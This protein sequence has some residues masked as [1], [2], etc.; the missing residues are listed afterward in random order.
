MENGDLLLRVSEAEEPTKKTILHTGTPFSHTHAHTHTHTRHDTT[1]VC[2]RVPAKITPKPI[3][4]GGG[5]FTY[6]RQE[7]GRTN[8]ALSISSE[9]LRTIPN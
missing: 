9:R 8:Y 1:R 6:S 2:A 4:G 3:C 7:T 5:G